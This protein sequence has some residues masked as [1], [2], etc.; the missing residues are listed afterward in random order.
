MQLR[1]V[2]VATGEFGTAALSVQVIPGEMISVI[3]SHTD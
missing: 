1:A 2:D 3:T